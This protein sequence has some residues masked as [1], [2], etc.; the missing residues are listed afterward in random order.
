MSDRTSAKS[1]AGV[2]AVAGLTLC[3]AACDRSDPG[4]APR[5]TVRT[6]SPPP[7]A[8][9]TAPG[10][11]QQ[12]TQPLAEASPSSAQKSS[13]PAHSDETATNS[14]APMKPMDKNEESKSMP[15]PGQVND[16]STLAQDPKLQT[17]EPKTTQ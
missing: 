3:L 8:T 14:D 17:Q 6:P 11:S 7:T 2:A 1:F 4:A 9:S 10:S 15:Q 13:D 16:H 5:E 12:G